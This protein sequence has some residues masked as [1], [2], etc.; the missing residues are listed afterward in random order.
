MYKK[1]YLLAMVLC[2][3]NAA[4]GQPVTQKPAV[5]IV[6]SALNEVGLLTGATG[7]AAVL[8]TIHGVRINR[9]FT[10]IGAGIDYYGMR[11]VPLF[12]NVQ[13]DLSDKSKR[14]FLFASGG[15]NMPWA[16]S[17]Q[18]ASKGYIGEARKGLY[19]D[20]G[21][22]MKLQTKSIGAVVFSAGFS[23]KKTS[24]KVEMFSL[25]SSYWPPR[26][27][28]EYFKYQYRRIVLKLGLQL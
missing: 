8:Q 3:L 9:W 6:Y 22:G 25:W 5:K 4:T 16:T 2:V 13:R 26:P 1:I 10:G 7:Q 15:V 20:G 21:I 24:D 17:T 23:Y 11:S 18:N 27:S 28:D 14:P 19:V 12:L